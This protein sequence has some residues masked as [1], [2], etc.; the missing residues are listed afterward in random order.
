MTLQVTHI[1]KECKK[2]YTSRNINGKVKLWFNSKCCVNDYN[3][4]I[5]DP[6]ITGINKQN[7]VCKGE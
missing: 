6:C 5:C 7:C 1:C 4:L 2:E 3:N